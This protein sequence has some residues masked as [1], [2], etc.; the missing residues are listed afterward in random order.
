MKTLSLRKKI[1]IFIY[2]P[3]GL[4]VGLS[5]LLITHYQR[6]KIREETLRTTEGLNETIKTIL[7]HDM[8]KKKHDDIPVILKALEKQ[9][10]VLSSLVL[11]VEG[12]ITFSSKK[13]MVGKLLEKEDGPTCK[14]CHKNNAQTLIKTIIYTRSDGQVIL[15][16]VNPIYNEKR[17]HTPVC[18][19]LPGNKINGILITDVS[20]EKLNEQVSANLRLM[21]LSAFITFIFLVG[22]TEISLSR[23]VTTPISHLLKATKEICSGNLEYK[24]PLRKK[25]E[26][27]QVVDSFNEM[28]TSLLHA[29]EEL[30]RTIEELGEKNLELS[31]LYG[32]IQRI[33]STIEIN[34]LI[35]IVLDLLENVL[36]TDRAYLVVFHQ[37]KSSSSTLS[38][39]RNGEIEHYPLELLEEWTDVEDDEKFLSL[40]IQEIHQTFSQLGEA[41]SSETNDGL[42]LKTFLKSK[43]RKIGALVAYKEQRA[44]ISRIDMRL[45]DS[46]AKSLSMAL[47]NSILYEM[48]ITDSLTGLYTRRFF[49]DFLEAEIERQKRVKGS[50]SL[51]F[52]D[53]DH[54]K[55]INDQFGHSTGDLALKKVAS[56]I[57]K[58]IRRMDIASRFGGDEFAVILPGSS[59]SDSRE[60]ARRL[61]VYLNGEGKN[62]EK[63][64]LP[65][66]IS[67]SIGLASYPHDG[68]DVSQ[69]IQ[70]ADEAMYIAKTGE[71]GKIVLAGS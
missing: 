44:D 11:D 46:L 47:Y 37:G 35:K 48:A 55:Q 8:L 71:R 52:I 3:L 15:R 31:T 50:L 28:S 57:R 67:L 26:I 59:A 4:I 6:G 68:E 10:F 41:H 21:I 64:Q 45:F 20:M 9:K 30:K 69:F 33:T 60:V 70:K 56:M 42:A 16:T 39:R 43:G 12:N 1:M 29:R 58:S 14:I 13:E 63:G 25:D 23:V 36:H 66:S 17:C 18:H 38:I 49:E 51:I 61:I 62:G 34:D 27:G 53:I 65:V 32:L 7:I 24:I 2:L 54:F 19:H 5:F 22:I 40:I